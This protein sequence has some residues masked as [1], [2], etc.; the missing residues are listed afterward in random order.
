MDALELV[1]QTSGL[2]GAA[3]AAFYFAPATIARGQELGLDRVQF[4]GLGR[5]GVLGDVEPNVTISPA[6]CQVV[7][8]VSCLR[9]SSTTSD[10]PSLVR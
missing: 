1:H 6:A 5:G 7:P 10:Q 8:E 9:S 4:Y 2:I 3:G